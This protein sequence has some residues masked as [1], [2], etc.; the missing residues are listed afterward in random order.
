[1][2]ATPAPHP[3]EHQP[4]AL[5][6]GSVLVVEERFQ[7]TEFTLYRHPAGWTAVHIDDPA[8]VVEGGDWAQVSAEC[9][10]RSDARALEQV[11]DGLH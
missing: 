4:P 8:L 6:P 2:V 1:M 11:L 5:P 3:P 10:R 9:G 7:I